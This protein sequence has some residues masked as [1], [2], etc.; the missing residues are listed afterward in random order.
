MDR[1]V[2]QRLVDIHAGLVPRGLPPDFCP[3]AFYLA[4]QILAAR[5]WADLDLFT[6]VARLGDGRFVVLLHTPWVIA[7]RW[8]P[9][10]AA[11]GLCLLRI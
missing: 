11:H 2:D 7:F 8:S 3:M 10:A 6:P 5:S 4:R 9:D 1:I